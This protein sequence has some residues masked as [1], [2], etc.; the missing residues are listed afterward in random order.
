MLK[1][2]G[3]GLVE[4]RIHRRIERIEIFAEAQTVELLAPLLNGLR[5]GSA[6]AAA[7]IAQ[8]REQADRGAAQLRRNV[9]ERSDV[10]RRKNHREAHDEN[11]ARPDDLPGADLEIQSRHP[12]ISDAQDEQ[13]RGHEIARIDAAAEQA[14]DDDEHHDRE[15]AGRRK[16]ESGGRGVVAEERLEQGRET[17]GVGVERA[18]RAE[19][20]DAA[21]AKISVVERAEIDERIGDS[22]S[23]GQIK[24]P[25]PS[26]NRTASV[27][28]R[29]KDRRTNP[30]PGL[31]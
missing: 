20:D 17:Y 10:E 7:F 3:L 23:R 2:T 27:C 9:Q 29:R 16:H 25:R 4:I 13:A 28:T 19:D 8:Q 1:K 11:D 14:T 6:D 30:I 15:D 22:A 31:C 24:P 5:D 26:T 12:I 21:D 18:E